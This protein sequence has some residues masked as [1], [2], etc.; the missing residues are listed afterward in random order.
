MTD[1]PIRTAVLRTH[2]EPIAARVERQGAD[3]VSGGQIEL[4][5]SGR[6]IP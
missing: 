3:E 4:R 2:R 6:D 1:S 5:P